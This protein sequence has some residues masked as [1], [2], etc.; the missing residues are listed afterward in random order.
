MIRLR[1]LAALL[2]LAGC[3]APP[4]QVAMRI[5]IFETQGSLPYYVMQEQRLDKKHGLIFEEASYSGGPAVLDALAAGSLDLGAVVGIAPLLLAAESG[6]LPGK[7]V[8]VAAQNF[9]DGEHPGAGV[10]VGGNVQTWKDL[11]GKAIGVNARNSFVAA[12]VRIRL[13]REGAQG[14]SLVEVPFPNLGLAL[15]GG[16]IAAAVIIE[17]YLTQSLLRRDGRL[18]GWVIGG[19]PFERVQYESIVF[20]ADFYRRNPQGVKAYLRAHLAAVQWINDHPDEARLVLA[21]RLHVAP[22]LA[23][24]IHL[25]RFPLDARSDPALLEETQ[26]VL[27]GAGLLARPVDTRALHDETLLAEVLKEKR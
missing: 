3:E 6:Q 25:R 7:L 20:S 5:G 22:E 23:R 17:P 4:P 9:A 16:S 12:A 18:L 24:K 15:A 10:L 11:Q 26:K 19:P 21:K 8:A 14:F 13:E 27:L 1:I 2:A